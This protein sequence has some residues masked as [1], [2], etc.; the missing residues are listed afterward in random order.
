VWSVTGTINP[1]T[2]AFSI[3]ATHPPGL[4]RVKV[5]S[6]IGQLVVDHELK[7]KTESVGYARR[8]FRD[9]KTLVEVMSSTASYC[10][11]L[12]EYQICRLLMSAWTVGS[13]EQICCMAP[14][15]TKAVL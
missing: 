9:R 5:A 1:N 13:A 12:T 6:C 15:V 3:T 14:D 8:P 2:G 10:R 11:S 4:L 7:L